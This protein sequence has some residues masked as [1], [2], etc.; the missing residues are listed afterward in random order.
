LIGIATTAAVAGV[1]LQTSLQT[2]DF[3]KTWQEK[4]YNLWLTQNKVDIDLQSRVSE[5]EQAVQWLGD[6]L[7]NL[8]QVF[9]KCDWNSSS[10]CVTPYPFNATKHSWEQIK[11]HLQNIQGNVSLDIQALQQEIFDAFKDSIPETQYGQLASDIVH[12]LEGLDP[13]RWLQNIIHGLGGSFFAILTCCLI[14][15]TGFCI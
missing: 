11:Y 4:S 7:V 10:V 13:H 6:Q 2:H 5:L 1:A 3:V 9:L 12:A 15:L 8:Q 14:F